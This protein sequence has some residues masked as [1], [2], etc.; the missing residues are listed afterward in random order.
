MAAILLSRRRR[1]KR[2]RDT[3]SLMSQGRLSRWLA[4]A[5]CALACAHEVAKQD[6]LKGTSWQLV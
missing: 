5:L 2:A 6:E 4:L 1:F 3:L